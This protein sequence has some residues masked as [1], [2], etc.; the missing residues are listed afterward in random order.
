M[1]MVLPTRPLEKEHFE[2]DRWTLRI[3]P[4]ISIFLLLIL[5][6]TLYV[7]QFQHLRLFNECKSVFQSNFSFLKYLL[8]TFTNVLIFEHYVKDIFI[9]KILLLT[10][11]EEPFY[12]WLVCFGRFPKIR[13][14]LS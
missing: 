8:F 11:I 12:F 5:L 10:S 4:I 14:L 1:F 6:L 2:L 3:V 9:L 7:C 13:T